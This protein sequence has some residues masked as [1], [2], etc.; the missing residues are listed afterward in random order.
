VPRIGHSNVVLPPARARV[1][2]RDGAYI[3]TGGMGG[4]GLFLADRMAAAGCGRIVLTSRSRPGPHAQE[5]IT[6]MRA[7]GADVQVECGDIAEPATAQHLVAAATATGLPLRGVVHAAGVVYD[8]T[9]GSITDELIDRDWAAKVYGAWHLHHA[10]VGQ[11]LDWFCSFSSTAAML[12]SP[13]QGAY[14]AANSW[15]DAFTHWRRSQGL[16][17]TAIAWGAWAD[18]GRGAVLAERGDTTMIRPDDGAY[19]F[20]QV[21]RHDRAHTGYFPTT[22]APWLTALASHSPIAEAFLTPDGDNSSGTQTLLAELHSLPRD[23]WLNR[24]R[25]LVA[26]QLSLVLRQTIDPDRPFADHGLDSLGKLELRTHIET[27]TGIRISP[28]AMLTHNTVRALAQH[29]TDVLSAEVTS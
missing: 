12:G 21:L 8:A 9:L 4:L 20:E 13:G 25:R 1:F 5:A 3:I 7:N 29:L 11:S 22:G 18:I 10:T 14:A 28:K 17:A 6:R 2:R 27:E 16:P 19:A 23:Q 15:L 26:D 24:L